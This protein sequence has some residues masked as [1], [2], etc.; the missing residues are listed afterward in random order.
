MPENVKEEG[1][2]WLPQKP[3]AK[4][5]GT[6]TFSYHD[7]VRL[8]LL[9]NFEGDA[10]RD[11]RGFNILGES[12]FGNPITIYQ[13]FFESGQI[14]GGQPTGGKSSFVAS[15]AFV[16]VH[17]PSMDEAIF[18]TIAFQMPHFDE[19]LQF[20]I[21]DYQQQERGF[22]ISYTRP[23]AL[24]FE[25]TQGISLGV[26]FTREG[27]QIGHAVTDLS[28]THR[29]SFVITLADPAHF[30]VFAEIVVH[31]TNLLALAVVAPVRPIEVQGW[32]PRPEG[33]PKA[34]M[35]PVQVLLPLYTSPKEDKIYHFHMLF[36]Y[37][38]VKDTF[39]HLLENWF[40]KRD[41][42]Q[43]VFDL[44]FG[45]LYNPNPYPVT[46]FLN[47]VQAIETYHIRT[48]SNEVDSPD[49]HKERVRAILAASPD[50]YR[51]W[52]ADKLAFS[53]RPTLAHR[54]REVIS[55]YPFPVTG[56]AGSHE[57][58]ITRVRDTR[59]YHT[60]YDPSLEEKAQKGGYLKGLSITLG[61]LLEGLIL[62][63]LGFSYDK[64]RD[65]QYHRRRL[66]S[67]WF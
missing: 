3:E 24:T 40:Q 31:L 25:P 38:S 61:T 14:P 5:P 13:A 50:Q 22:S 34:M 20:D 51:S 49:L 33:K 17:F 27:P 23:D 43:P 8:E 53:N 30:D 1:Y 41:T 11:P 45:V 28:F 58:F 56:Q 4:I 19:W 37:S 64:V 21:L 42:L 44:F 36:T 57:A 39:P 7:G 2:W 12:T 52:L 29:A 6:L 16:G 59:N 32:L 9:G 10:T 65:M 15:K 35:V 18:K 26:S 54:L 66:P 62:H 55:A 48:M 47:Y 63:E 67:V 60:H 46:T